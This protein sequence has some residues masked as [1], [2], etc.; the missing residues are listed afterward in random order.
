VLPSLGRVR[1]LVG[2]ELPEV[3]EL[4][5]S[6]L[7]EAAQAGPPPTRAAGALLCAASFTL[8]TQSAQPSLAEAA[9][10]LGVL[11][12]NPRLPPAALEA[13][14]TELGSGAAGAQQAPRV[15]VA[16]S[17]AANAMTLQVRLMAEGLSVQRTRTRAETEKAVAAGANAIILA[18]TLPDGET[19]ALVR[20]IRA[21]PATALLP[22]FLLA[23]GDDLEVV[24]AG[25]EAGADDVLMRPINIEVL[26][27]KLR[28]ALAQRQVPRRA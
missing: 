25:L 27:A 10:A 5:S 2:N 16:D 9:K 3:V 23:S 14:T 11:R 6:V 13:L 28:R 1:A 20:A 18:T 24:T 26:T 12:Q 17:D 8:Q 4:L 7:A 19:H 21:A 22:V 15:L